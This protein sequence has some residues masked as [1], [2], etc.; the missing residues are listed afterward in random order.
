[1]VVNCDLQM[2]GLGKFIG[3]LTKCYNIWDLARVVYFYSWSFYTSG[4]LDKFHCI[5]ICNSNDFQLVT[6]VIRADICMC[7]SKCATNMLS[8]TETV[9]SEH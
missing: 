4:R 9:G 5:S 7:R 6:I 3:L 8:D 1:M 2:V